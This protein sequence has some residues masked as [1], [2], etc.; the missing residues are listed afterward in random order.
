MRPLM[1]SDPTRQR[2]PPPGAITVPVGADAR[3]AARLLAATGQAL[4]LVTDVGRPVGVVT[5]AA[6][7]GV[8]GRG[9][10]GAVVADAMDLEVVRVDPR[11][12]EPTTVRAY[13]EAAWASLR[14]RHPARAPVV[15]DRGG[16]SPWTAHPAARSRPTR[17][18]RGPS[19]APTSMT[20]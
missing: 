13:D 11:A 20:W 12:D 15:R 14:R 19:R 6:L 4:A 7:A 18:A 17:S 10:H 16:G 5:T 2:R 3:T 8:T 1:D 9:A